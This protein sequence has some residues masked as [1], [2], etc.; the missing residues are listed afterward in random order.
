[1]PLSTVAE[2]VQSMTNFESVEQLQSAQ[3]D[4]VSNIPEIVHQLMKDLTPPSST[5][6][7]ISP[8]EV[9]THVATILP[10]HIIEESEVSSPASNQLILF[11]AGL[12]SPARS[13]VRL[14]V[15]ND[16]LRTAMIN[17][18]GMLQRSNVSSKD[19][20][21]FVSSLR[22]SMLEE[23]NSLAKNLHAMAPTSNLKP[24]RLLQIFLANLLQQNNG[25]M[26]TLIL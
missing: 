13:P 20:S 2:A 1:M 25:W 6:I 9:A 12:K 17:L 24:Q 8:L 14:K 23:I 19:A 10:P 5:V 18:F 22:R 3:I 4:H 26:P 15:T 7:P 21:N 11:E 16:Q